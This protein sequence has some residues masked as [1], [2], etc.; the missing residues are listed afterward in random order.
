[1]G[2]GDFVPLPHFFGGD[3]PAITQTLKGGLL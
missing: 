1:V 2:G 3:N